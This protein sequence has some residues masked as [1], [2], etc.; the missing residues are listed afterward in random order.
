M[1]LDADRRGATALEFTLCFP[2]VLLFVFGTFA[3]YSMVSCKRAMDVGVERALRY[4]S[5]HS[6]EGAVKA[7]D[8]YISAA[9]VIWPGVGS[10]SSVTV[11]WSSNVATVSASYVWA[12]PAGLGTLFNTTLFNGVTLSAGGKMRVVN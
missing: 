4:A 8:A 7:T 12:A 1:R 6:A 5:V 10:G 2:A 3:I 11:S 9:R